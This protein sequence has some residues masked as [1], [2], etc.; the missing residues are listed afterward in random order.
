[1]LACSIFTLLRHDVAPSQS[2][3]FGVFLVK[4][5]NGSLTGKGL[6]KFATLKRCT[7]FPS[8]MLFCF[9]SFPFQKQQAASPEDV[10]GR[11]LALIK[12]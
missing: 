3:L 9:V 4:P 10:K 1:M 7:G 5:K 12:F 11:L 2:T 6:G 8:Q